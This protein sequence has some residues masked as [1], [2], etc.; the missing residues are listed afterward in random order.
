[1]TFLHAQKIVGSENKFGL[2][3]SPVY[4]PFAT[5][6]NKTSHSG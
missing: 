2:V 4:Q 5:N 3:E 6:P 1:M